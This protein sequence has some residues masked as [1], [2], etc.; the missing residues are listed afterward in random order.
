MATYVL[1]HGAGS[2]SWYWHRVVPLLRALGH[3]VVAPDLPCGDDGAGLE[4]YADTV[5]RAVGRRSPVVLV[6]QSMAG[7]TAPLVATRVPTDLLVL[8]AAMV[9]APGESPGQ[10]WDATGHARARRE[11]DQLEGRDPDAPFDP[12]AVFFHDVP[13]DV[14][15]EAFARED[16]GQSDTPFAQPWPLPAWPDVPTRVLIASRDRFFPAGFQRRLASERLGVVPEEIDTGHLP[17]LARPEEL[18]QRLEGYRLE[19]ERVRAGA[20]GGPRARRGPAPGR[21]SG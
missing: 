3:E 11:L 16:P 15:A 4:E 2:D 8:V 1:V 10:W 17:A 20:A 12:R 14:V 5:V 19:Q 18:V 21:R 13:R 6:A 9:P 7:F